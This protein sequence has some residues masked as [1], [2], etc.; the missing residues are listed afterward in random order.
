MKED[1]GRIYL[2]G[3]RIYFRKSTK[4]FMVE[5][6]GPNYQIYMDE[7]TQM[8]YIALRE[9][10]LNLSLQGTDESTSALNPMVLKLPMDKTYEKWIEPKN[11][12]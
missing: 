1:K 2:I 10:A 3:N 11:N 6:K 8:V 5:D 7:F 9:G 12:T 4:T